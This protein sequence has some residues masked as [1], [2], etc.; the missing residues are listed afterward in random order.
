MA[1]NELLKLMKMIVDER[2]KTVYTAIPA[3]VLA[4]DPALQQAQIEL[5]ILRTDVNGVVSVPPPI[6]KCP[7]LFCGQG[8]SLEHEIN[9]G[10]EGLAIFS[11][12]CI[13]GWV[14]TGGTADNPL[15]RFHDMQDALF[16][17]GFRPEPTVIKNFQNSGIR[18]RN[19]EGSQFV[20]MKPDGSIVVEN[21]KGHIRM[22]AEG[23]VTINRVTFFVDGRVSSPNGITTQGD[24]SAGGVS[25]M[26]HTHSGVIAGGDN[27]GAPNGVSNEGTKT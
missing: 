7:V 26:R 24:V 20:W 23:N 5:G 16:I 1:E 15:A 14:T 27:T 21:G 11:Q 13:D 2:M 12:R 22:D 10:C 19:A 3:H 18:L 6:I 4:F 17:P 9:P 8:F 25:V